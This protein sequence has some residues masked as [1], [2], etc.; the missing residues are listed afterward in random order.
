[1]KKSLLLPAFVMLLLFHS[2]KR[3]DPFKKEQK[4]I[5]EIVSAKGNKQVKIDVDNVGEK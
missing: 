4:E 3:E 1:M 2:S 5:D